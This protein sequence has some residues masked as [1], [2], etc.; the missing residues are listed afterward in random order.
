M[1]YSKFSTA[2]SEYLSEQLNFDDEKK[3]VV[4]YGLEKLIY[5]GLGFSAII[6][7]GWALGVE[8]EAAMA[9]LA[10]ALLRKYSG[11]SHSPTALRC[12]IYGAVT[13]P[14]A[15][16]LAHFIFMY[17]GP[18]GWLPGIF[19][20]LM[21]LAVVQRYAPVDSPGKPIVS[22]EFRQSLH[23][24]SLVVAAA[25]VSAALLLHETSLSLAILAGL[26][27]QTVSLLPISNRRR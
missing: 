16:W 17:Y 18:F 20:G 9:L 12:I 5:T 27:L 22:P 3:E 23:R 25:F 15:A 8:K 2:A 24:K 26:A 14:A 19:T 11:G 6:L 4:A 1:A 13:Y 21:I 7:V 10:G